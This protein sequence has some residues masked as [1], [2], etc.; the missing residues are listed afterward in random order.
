MCVLGQDSGHLARVADNLEMLQLAD[1]MRSVTGGGG[2][3]RE[4]E[5]PPNV[6]SS[7]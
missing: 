4:I 5:K 1:E 2:V 6:M 7:A 3:S